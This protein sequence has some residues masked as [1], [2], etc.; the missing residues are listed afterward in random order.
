M[1]HANLP[2]KNGISLKA[3]HYQDILSTLPDVGW[4]EI[5]PENYMSDGGLDH[6]FLR[7]ISQHYPISMHGVGMSLGSANSVCEDHLQQL[8]RLVDTYQPAQVSEHI[9]W[10]QLDGTHLNDL[11]PLPYTNET[12]NILCDNIEKVQST[13]GKT[14]LVENPSTYIDFENQDYSEPDFL[15]AIA[16]RSG[17]GLLLDINNIF[18]SASNN[19]FDPYEY[20]NQIP[21]DSIGEIHLAGHSVVP[22]TEYKEIRIDDHSR[23]VSPQVWALYQHAIRFNNRAFPTLIEW[24][25]NIPSLEILVKESK[26]AHKAMQ[27]ALQQSNHGA[28][29]AQ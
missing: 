13:L 1:P 17:C 26:K 4:L 12:L 15:K 3:Q 10:T 16:K 14:I 2:L 7:E 20:L 18:V 29:N 27:Y 28:V 19:A 11:L 8:K 9:A 6:K 23:E 5:H 24:D 21:A 25:T 22:L